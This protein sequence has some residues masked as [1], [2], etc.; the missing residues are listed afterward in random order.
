M[1]TRLRRYVV[2]MGIV[3][4][5]AGVAGCGKGKGTVSGRVT[6]GG[7]PVVSGTVSMIASDDIQY[8]G[9]ISPDGTYSIS[10][11]PNGPVRI[12]VSSPNSNAVKPG[13]PP[14]TSGTQGDIEGAPAQPAAKPG[15]WTELPGK[16][17]DP[18]QSGLT[19]TV[20]SNTIINLDL[21]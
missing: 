11:V 2:G 7:K 13:G 8:S 3:C 5:L 9:S 16:Y 15:E 21:E 14:P 6:Y 12:L 1:S 20:K 19:G 10:G 4:L 18:A 17:A